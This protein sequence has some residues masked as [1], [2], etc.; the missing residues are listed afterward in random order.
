MDFLAQKDHLFDTF[1]E[2]FSLKHLRC[3]NVVNQ[4]LNF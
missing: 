4:P 1:F 2:Y 3:Q